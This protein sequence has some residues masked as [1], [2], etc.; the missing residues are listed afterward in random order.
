MISARITWE[1]GDQP[2]AL[3][4]DSSIS[5]DFDESISEGMALIRS[6]DPTP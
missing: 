5:L 6:A 1:F 4:G 2:Q 3:F